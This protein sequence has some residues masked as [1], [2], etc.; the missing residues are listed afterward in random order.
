MRL[1]TILLGLALFGLMCHAQEMKALELNKIRLYL[2]NDALQQRIGDVDP[3]VTY[4]KSLQ[5]KA[6]AFW[7]KAVAPRA[8]GLFIAVGVKSNNKV[9][10]WCEAVDG[11]IPADAL[12]NLEKQLSQVALV[13]VKQG[14]IAFAIEMKAAGQ[15][16]QHYPEMPK[17]W[18][19]A[20]KKSKEPLMIPDG[21]FK[22]V[23]PD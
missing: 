20:A 16:P 19:E 5:K 9:K 21:L 12:S 11:E 10:L 8:K 1:L 15:N 3:L 7:E 2:S 4:V 14:S 6:S 23:W 17:S 18:V 22:V 13:A